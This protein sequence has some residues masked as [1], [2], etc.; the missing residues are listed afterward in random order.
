MCCPRCEKSSARSIP[1]FLGT[2]TRIFIN[3]CLNENCEC[4][5][6]ELSITENT[7]RTIGSFLGVETVPVETKKES[8]EESEPTEEKSPNASSVEYFSLLNWR[9]RKGGSTASDADE[10]PP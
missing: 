10:T 3:D 9:E 2:V 4:H 6:K 7:E 5:I 1:T 8:K